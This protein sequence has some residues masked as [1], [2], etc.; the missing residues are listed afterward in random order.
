MFISPAHQGNNKSLDS[1]L[2]HTNGNYTTETF[3]VATN[4]IKDDIDIGLYQ[5]SS[6]GDFVWEDK[7]LNGVQDL[8]ELGVEQIQLQLFDFQDRLIQTTQTDSKGKYKFSNLLPGKYYIQAQANTYLITSE[9]KGRDTN[10]DSDFYAD[11]KTDLFD[12]PFFTTLEDV[13]LGLIKSAAACGQVW[14]D[15]N[16]NGK[17]DLNEKFVPSKKCYYSILLGR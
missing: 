6:I 3:Y 7:N 11:G 1:D 15:A 16:Q 8:S 12:L 2:D 14:F 4:T 9:N 10:K 17:Q 5:Y 13:D